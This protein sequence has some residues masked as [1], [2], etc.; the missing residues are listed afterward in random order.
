MNTFYRDL[1]FIVAL[2]ADG[3][4]YAIKGLDRKAYDQRLLADMATRPFS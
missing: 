4:W 2:T 1:N 3:P